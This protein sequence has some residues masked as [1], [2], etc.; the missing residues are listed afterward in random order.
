MFSRTS[1]FWLGLVC[2]AMVLAGCGTSGPKLIPVSGTVTY[3][4]KPVEGAVVSFQCQGAPKMATGTTD[5]QGRF[6]LA[7][8]KPGDGTIAGKHKVTVRKLVREG[9]AAS[10]PMSMEDAMKATEAPKTQPAE[11]HQLPMK[12][13][14]AASSDLEFTVTE[15]GPNDFTIELKD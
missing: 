11:R 12:Y 4:G 10:G 8:N 1:I 15:A 13:A 2:V 7:T 14:D 3:N 9:A 6:Q 5:A